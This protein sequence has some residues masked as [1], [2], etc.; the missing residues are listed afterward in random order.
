MRARSLALL[1]QLPQ[2]ARRWNGDAV[3]AALFAVALLA[4]YANPYAGRQQFHQTAPGEFT[5]S[6]IADWSGPPDDPAAETR[7]LGE[8]ADHVR[9]NKLCPAGARAPVRRDDG[10]TTGL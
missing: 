7:R 8:V 1:T 6:T 5:Y 4:G 9:T 3:A 10:G 2:V